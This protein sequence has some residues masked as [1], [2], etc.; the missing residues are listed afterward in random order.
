MTSANNW[1]ID[2]SILCPHYERDHLLSCWRLKPIPDDWK[3]MFKAVGFNTPEQV[4]KMMEFYTER[5]ATNDPEK[6]AELY[7]KIVATTTMHYRRIFIDEL[8][9]NK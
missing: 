8:E 2:D 5:A 9:N 3:V 6:K 4:A 1:T 7:A